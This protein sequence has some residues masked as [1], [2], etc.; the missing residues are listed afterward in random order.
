MKFVFATNNSTKTSEQ[1]VERLAKFGVDVEPWQVITSSQAAAHA[2]AQKF[3]EGTKVFMIG[4]DG[5]QMALEEKG[6]EI[7]SVEYAKEAQA[8]VMGIDRGINFDKVA[9]ATLL[10]RNGIP[11]YATNTDATFPTPRGEIP[12]SGA[13]ISIITTATGVQPIIAG[14]P[15]PFLMELSLEKLGTKK[16][17]TLVVGDRIETD[18]AAGQGVGC[19]CAMVLSGVSTKKEADSWEPKIDIVADDLASLIE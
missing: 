4:E 8:F 1:Y 16:E 10:V 15:Y 11:F 3:P 7:V 18:I 9:E 5:I 17:E 13:W 6:F 2:V 12:G 14:K 19:P